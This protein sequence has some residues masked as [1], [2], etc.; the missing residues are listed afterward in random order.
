VR[1][2]AKHLPEV[3]EPERAAFATL[4]LRLDDTIV[5]AHEALGHVARDGAWVAKGELAGVERAAAVRD[6][7]K[8]ALALEIPLETGPGDL[9]FVNEL[10]GAPGKRVG[11]GGWSFHSATMSPE[12]MANTLRPILRALALSRWL[13][14]GTLAVPELRQPYKAVMC[15]Q[16]DEYVRAIRMSLDA[17]A[18]DREE[19]SIAG[20]VTHYEDGRGFRVVDE[21]SLTRQHAGMLVSLWSEWTWHRK[22]KHV[23]P[24]LAVGHLNWLALECFGRPIPGFVWREPDDRTSAR[25]EDMERRRKLFKAARESVPN[26]KRY[27]QYLEQRGQGPAFARAVQDR[28][29]RIRGDDLIKCTLVV[30]YLQEKERFFPLVDATSREPRAVAAI[31]EGLGEHLATLEERWR[32]WLLPMPLGLVARIEESA[33]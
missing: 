27:L 8:R 26:A 3:P 28:M 16:H 18:I 1:G 30:A 10:Q 4:V 5:P 12:R 7:V 14:D 9:E 6:A 13:D 21:E 32:K 23:Q 2:I 24:C 19:A 31:E 17:R 15:G 11:F 22:R 25:P 20:E 33:R 29:G